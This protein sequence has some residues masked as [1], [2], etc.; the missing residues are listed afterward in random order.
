MTHA[1]HSREFEEVRQL[2]LAAG[3]GS[4]V[5]TSNAYE[6]LRPVQATRPA[7]GSPRLAALWD[8][9]AQLE[10]FSLAAARL[11]ASA[12]ARGRQAQAV[13]YERYYE[14]AR[15]RIHLLRMALVWIEAA[16]AAID[17]ARGAGSGEPPAAHALADGADSLAAARGAPREHS[18]TRVLHHPAL[19][20]RELEIGALIVRGYTNRQIAE[21]LVITPGTAANHV[22]NILRKLDCTNRPQVVAALLDQRRAS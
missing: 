15:V 12:R 2:W 19:T 9:I 20:A 3:N 13:Q 21:A 6:A 10:A 22:S 7:D 4:A 11:A 18:S 1:D 14:K 17:S 8:G 16:R 5:V